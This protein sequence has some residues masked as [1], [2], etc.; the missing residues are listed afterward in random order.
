V[1]E[2]G[3]SNGSLYNWR[4]QY[5]DKGIAVP[6][7]DSKA[8]N[9]SAE[10]KL[11]VVFETMPLNEA[12]LSEYCRSKGLYVEQIRQWKEAALTG[13]Q[14]TAQTKK[15]SAANHKSDQKKIKKLE[16]ELRR[17]DKAL[18]ETAALLVLSKKCQAIWGENED[19]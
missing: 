7:D 17:K 2:T 4:K 5:R 13:Y 8:E 18:A 1:K 10:D 9:W 11:A 3:V 6:G 14:S 16:A 15:Q 19:D 12:N